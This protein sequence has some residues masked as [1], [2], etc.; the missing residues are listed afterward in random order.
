MR[1]HRMPGKVFAALA[2]G[3]GGAHAIGHLQAA[4]YSKRL[5]LLRGVR[6]AAKSEEPA[7][8]RR[9]RQAYAVLAEIQERAPDA[10]DAVIRYPSVGAWARDVLMGK[11]DSGGLASLTAAAAIQAGFSRPIEVPSDNGTVVLPSLGRAFVPSGSP[12][13]VRPDV[14]EVTVPGA[15][16]RIPPDPHRDAPGWQGVRRLNAE[17]HGLAIALSFDEGDPYRMPGGD[18]PDRRLT[19]AEIESWRA[20]LRRAWRLLVR[21]HWTTAEEI[22]AAVSVVTPLAP[23]AQA[24][25]HTSATAH[26]TFGSIAMSLPPDEHAMAVT[27]AHELQHTKLGALMDIV[28]LVLPDDGSRHYAPWRDD[29]RPIGG[30]LHGVYAHLGIAGFWRR[31]RAHERGETALRAHTEFARWRDAS[32]LGARTLASS[33]RLTDAGELFVAEMTR[34]LRTWRRE[35]VPVEALDRARTFAETHKARWRANNGTPSVADT[36][37]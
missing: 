29:P 21:R 12:A 19:D 22:A 6:D 2:A 9:A 24:G 10:V 13:M 7:R 35:P 11:G 25:E 18:V 37:D 27:L 28:P 14:A 20:M 17:Y 26:Q 23:S 5:L 15:S 3:S 4:Q 33:G 30:L 1:R 31:Q 8:A 34:T 32:A 36:S 16:V